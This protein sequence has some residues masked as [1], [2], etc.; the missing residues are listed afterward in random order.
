MP[1]TVDQDLYLDDGLDTAPADTD[2]P[3]TLRFLDL[4]A[5]LEAPLPPIDWDIDPLFEAGTVNLIVAD[6][7]VGK[8][9]FALEMLLC[10]RKG[11]PFLGYETK[12]RIVSYIDL[13]NSVHEV[14]R[15][16]RKLGLAAADTDGLYYS[17]DRL[18]LASPAGLDILRA[19][20]VKHG[21]EVVVVDSFRRCALGVNENDSAAVA[22]FFDPLTGLRDELGVTLIILH[23]SRKENELAPTDSHQMVRGS[24]DFRGAVDGL[25]YLRR[26]KNDKHRFLLE[27][28]KIRS[29]LPIDP[30]LVYRENSAGRVRHINDG[31]AKAD[32]TTAAQMMLGTIL[33]ALRGEKESTL[34]RTA[35]SLRLGVT[36]NNGTFLRAIHLG[37]ESG[38]LATSQ[39][40]PRK[41]MEIGLG[42]D[43]FEPPG[44][45]AC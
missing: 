38:Q 34:T 12:R 13:E 5:M 2:E 32:T 36:T 20:I 43:S 22:L 40:A 45:L 15:R 21:L 44:V 25:L 4:Q 14:N 31:P 8:S 11:E 39:E 24:G 35:L 16:L 6:S 26:Q 37:R 27:Q 9:L 1:L 41:P 23:H 30:L 3:E 10:I 33:E 18:N 42:P 7:Y 17:K 19:T 29:G 28:D